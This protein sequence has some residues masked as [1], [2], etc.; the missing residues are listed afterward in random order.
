MMLAFPFIEFGWMSHFLHFW[1][2]LSHLFLFMVNSTFRETKL[3]LNKV[4]DFSWILPFDLINS[5]ALYWVSIIHCTFGISRTFGS[6]FPSLLSS[7]LSVVAMLGF[8]R[9]I[10]RL[11]NVVPFCLLTDR[12]SWHYLVN[13]FIIICFAAFHCSFFEFSKRLSFIW[14]GL[15]WHP[16]PST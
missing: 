5:Y 15:R 8:F 9:P 10:S 3:S 4:T 14:T 16:F 12:R 7:F 2:A 6:N 11:N 1:V 13:A